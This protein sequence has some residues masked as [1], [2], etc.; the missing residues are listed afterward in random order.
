M[1]IDDEIEAHADM[2]SLI[3]MLL[4]IIANTG[5]R[6]GNDISHSQPYLLNPNSTVSMGQNWLQL[7]GFVK[8]S[9]YVVFEGLDVVVGGGAVSHFSAATAKDSCEMHS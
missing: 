1:K 7:G 2:P 3:R 8:W 4:W 5:T 6:I 9:F